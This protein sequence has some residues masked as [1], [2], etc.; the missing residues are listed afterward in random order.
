MSSDTHDLLVKA[1]L[2]YCTCQDK[3]EFKGGDE[4]GVKA[5]I[6][7]GEIRR[8]AKIR[9]EEIQNKKQHRK[10]LRN[11][12]GGRPKKVIRSGETY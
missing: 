10:Q 12:Q 5:R 1:V 4:I 3:F 7:L 6:L 9:R 2:D 11:G 8:L